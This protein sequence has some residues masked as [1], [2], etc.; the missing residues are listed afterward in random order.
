MRR[1]INEKVLLQGYDVGF[2]LNEMHATPSSIML[3]LLDNKKSNVM[4]VGQHD[5]ISFKYEFRT[6]AATKWILRQDWI[7]DFDEY[8]EKDPQE[9]KDYHNK[10]VD[11][12]NDEVERF[13]TRSRAYRMKHGE[14][15][16][17][18]LQKLGHKIDSL[19]ILIYYL[20][21]DRTWP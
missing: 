17:D 20:E 11:E 9:L 10:I 18:K 16:H 3:E 6:S 21:H 19:D 4:V 8:V 12:Y 2:I 13:N 5:N 15:V 14:K 1:R 7:L